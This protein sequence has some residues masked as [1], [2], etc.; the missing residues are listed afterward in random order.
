M[1][2]VYIRAYTHR[3]IYTYTSRDEFQKHERTYLRYIVYYEQYA[4]LVR[5]VSNYM[6]KHITSHFIYTL[7][8]SLI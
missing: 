6:R 3:Y 8:K 1:Y 2:Q 4:S 7:V 5:A